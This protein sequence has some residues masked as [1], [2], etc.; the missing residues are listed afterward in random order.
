M[1]LGAHLST[2]GGLDQAPA[3]VAEIGGR[4]MQ[5]FTRNQR[6][7]RARPVTEEEARAFRRAREEEG[8]EYV[9]SHASY[10]FNPAAPDP[11]NL[12]RSRRLFA[13]EVDRCLALGLDAVVFHPGAAKEAPLPEARA[14]VA[15]S[16]APH[17]DRAAAGGLRVLLENTAGQGTVLGSTFEELAELIALMEDHPVLG[18]CF[19]TAHAWGAGFDIRG[20]KL[21]PRLKQVEEI[22]GPDRLACFHLNDTKVDL[23]SRKDRHAEIGEGLLGLETFRRLHRSRKYARLAGLL[24]TPGGMAGWKREIAAIKRG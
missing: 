12:A 24:E 1:L 23:G 11:T 15:E 6:T 18:I 22:L 20:T 8:V 3:K 7:W 2:A 10:L 13:E 14:R 21:M 9:I 17:L 5:I 16:V 4:A 19:D